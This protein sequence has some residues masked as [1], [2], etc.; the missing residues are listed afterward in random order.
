MCNLNALSHRYVIAVLLA[1]FSIWPDSIFAELIH[2]YRL[3][4]TFQHEM[5]SDAIG[6]A[7]GIPTELYKGDTGV[8]G[9][10]YFFDQT[11]PDFLNFGQANLSFPENEF[12][13]TF[14]VNFS[15][16]GMDEYERLL[17]S[18]DS[19]SFAELSKGFSLYFQGGAFQFHGSDGAN[20]VVTTTLPMDIAADSW[21]LV[22]LRYTPSRKPGRKADGQIKV[23][24]IALGGH[25]INEASIAYSTNS[26]L[27]MLGSLSHTS[28]LWVGASPALA[29]DVSLA[30]DGTL[31]DIR[32]YDNTLTDL[33]I[34]ELYNAAIPVGGALRWLFNV[35]GDFEG[36]TANNVVNEQ[37]DGGL[38]SMDTAEADP[39]LISPTSLKLD[40]TGVDNIYV[41]L[42]N[43][44][45]ATTARI[46]FQTNSAKDLAFHFVDFTVSAN[47]DEVKNY[48]VDMSQHSKWRGTLNRVRIDVPDG[49]H[50]GLSY[51]RIAIGQSANRPNIVF[52][53]ADDLGWRD[54]AVNGSTFYKT[55]TI[56]QL[57]LEGINYPNA[58][59]ANPLCSPTRAG[60]LTGQYPARLRFNSPAGHVATVT[61]DPTVYTSAEPYLP[62]TSVG[63]RTRLPNGYV[64]YAEVLKTAGYSTG[65]IGKWHLGKGRYIPEY[66]GFDYVIGGRHHPGPPGGYFAP[67]Y[68]DSNIPTI[69]PD[70]RRIQEGDHINDVLAAFA[71][72]FLEHNRNKPFLLNLWWY[73]VHSPFQAKSDLR[74]SYI[75]QS[76]ADGRQRSA[77]M[78]AMVESMDAGMG[79][80]LSKLE[81]LGLD[82]DTI[83]IFT[84]D[85]GGWMYTW[86][87]ED[88]AL[89]TNN[90]PSRGGKS[91]IWDGGSHVPFM[92]KWP[93]VVTPG[94]TSE[95]LINNMDVYA[96]ILDMVDLEPY[97]SSALDSRS[98]VPSLLGQPPLN[99][100]TIFVQFPISSPA[101]GTFPGAWVRQDNMK[102]IRFFHGNGKRND[103]RYEL[104]DIAADPT[105]SNNL[106]AR[107]A[108]LVKRLDGLLEAHLQDTDALIPLAN[109]AY[110][111]P[112]FQGWVPNHGVWV[113]S[114]TDGRL[115][116]MSNSFLPALD[117]PDLSDLGIPRVVRLQMQSRSHGNGRIWWKIQGDADFTLKQSMAFNVT[118][119]NIERVIE[120]P[121]DPGA[122]VTRIRFQPSSDYFETD[123]ALIEL[124]DK[125]GTSLANYSF[126]DS[127]GDGMRD[128]Q[129][130][131]NERD[132]RDAS[133]LAFEFNTNGDIQGWAGINITNLAAENG[134]FSGYSTSGDPHVYND[135]FSFDANRVSELRIRYRA[136]ANGAFQFFWGH[137][138]AHIASSI[139]LNYTGNGAWE[140]MRID[141][142]KIGAEW[143]DHNITL[144]RFDPGA[145]VNANW[146]IDWIRSMGSNEN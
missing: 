119:D 102:L 43:K 59:S 116:L 63:S 24:S 57:A 17:D 64:T 30:L 37:V 36:W 14:W 125:D 22:A 45:S 41:G 110:V 129:E 89:P 139:S 29:A 104:Y 99:N 93:G 123:V 131:F 145:T 71:V 39:Q 60:I 90:Y 23:S 77:T 121:I 7:K 66:Q 65:F 144:L 31:D 52:I 13:L 83:V 85:N 86:I 6:S 113:Q 78:G 73:D 49:V 9:G 109:P 133:D 3:D 76:S 92:V 79:V 47:D 18:G 16:S 132:P 61:L 15:S 26:L 101:T 130:V 82:D 142:S 111:P 141:T 48:V 12:T 4:E 53:M 87:T 146:A 34:A 103:H 95:D 140:N 112:V 70:G 56:D 114:G 118:H 51:D 54:V 35:D 108:G 80:L 97:D 143:D 106:A 46:H 19:V 136:D 135:R 2:H 88:L 68:S 138:S 74:N 75:G 120:V 98:L 126:L 25:T 69:L 20:K 72:D 100:D 42:M 44:T 10:A 8:H 32:I 81:S 62:S 5:V 1:F 11:R 55:P 58:F 84:S 28:E 127:D 117:S 40:L 67:F 38:Y 21:Y 128:Q 107:Q 134:L 105:E 33:E 27:H 94:Q 91:T 124:L 137:E 96:T 115:K 122:R 50:G